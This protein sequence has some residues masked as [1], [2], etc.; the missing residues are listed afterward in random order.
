MPS[1]GPWRVC[2]AGNMRLWPESSHLFFRKQKL[3]S[4]RTQ[5]KVRMSN[6]YTSCINKYIHK[7]KRE[8]SYLFKVVS[9]TALWKTEK[10]KTRENRKCSVT[11]QS[12]SFLK[13][14][15]QHYD[16]TWTSSWMCFKTPFRISEKSDFRHLS[17]SQVEGRCALCYL[18]C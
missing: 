6:L 10:G 3:C 13:H 2:H 8:V 12:G 14:I 9:V 7:Y 16:A 18:Q 5:G 11:W 15:L 4:C 17:L 1:G